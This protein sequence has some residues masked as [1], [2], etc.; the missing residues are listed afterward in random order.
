MAVPTAPQMQGN[1]GTEQPVETRRVECPRSALGEISRAVTFDDTSVRSERAVVL[2]EDL[3]AV[4]IR[5]LGEFL[6]EV[7]VRRRDMWPG[8]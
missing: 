6:D 2:N 1:E 7:V 8:G 5:C 4:G 3:R